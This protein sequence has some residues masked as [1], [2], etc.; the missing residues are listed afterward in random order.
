MPDI[1]R[2][3]AP[4]DKALFDAC[5]TTS[6]VTSVKKKDGQ[7]ELRLVT[8]AKQLDEERVQQSEIVKKLDARSER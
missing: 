3:R 4:S 6:S 2:C 8:F 7:V 1:D 5:S